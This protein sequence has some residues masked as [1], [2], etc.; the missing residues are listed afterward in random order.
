MPKHLISDYLDRMQTF[1]DSYTGEKK[2]ENKFIGKLLAKHFPFH[3]QQ[4]RTHPFT[5]AYVKGLKAADIIGVAD[6]LEQLELSEDEKDL[7]REYRGIKVVAHETNMPIEDID[8]YWNKTKKYSAKVQNRF[9]KKRGEQG[10]ENEINFDAI[11]SNKIKPV[12]VKKQEPKKGFFDRAVYTDTHI[13]MTPNKD[14]YSLYGGKWDEQEIKAR[15]EIFVSKILQEQKSNTLYLDELGDFMDGWDGKTVRR[16]HDLP[17]NMDNQKAYDVGLSFKVMLIDALIQHYDRI[18][19]HNICEDNHAGAF[20]YV[21]NSAFKTVMQY[22]YP[23]H[24]E[25]HNI[26]K[27]IDHYRVGKYVF[28]LT[29]G[30]DSKNL[31]FGFKPVLDPRQIEKINNYIDEHFLYTKDSVIEFSKG[32]SHQWYFDNSSSDK[33]NYYNY[34]AF[35]PSSEW[36]Q[37]N[38]KKGK[39]G[40]IVFNYFKNAQK[41]TS[42]YLFDWHRA[43][44][45]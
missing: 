28:I 21:V 11:F 42:E 24:V 32:D 41:S 44:T 36:V 1:L 27:F 17:Q 37:T 29:H 16:E 25:V 5:K 30:K 18:I 10:I 45:V 38:F 43:T 23:H 9:Y 6:K 2:A 8:F 20:G 12:Y 19:C 40:F 7:I 14:G 34:P 39:S 33:F 31:R 35:S 15:L 22:K 26:R 4:L 3:W 13:G